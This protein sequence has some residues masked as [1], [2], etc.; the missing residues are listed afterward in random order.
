[1]QAVESYLVLIF[2]L[3]RRWVTLNLFNI[4]FGMQ[5]DESYL[6]SIWFGVQVV[7]S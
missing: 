2:D 7:V 4:W 1:M 3:V 6:F 5:V